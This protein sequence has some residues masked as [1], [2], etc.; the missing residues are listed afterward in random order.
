MARDPI[1]SPVDV[2]P[3]PPRPS[4]EHLKNE[5]KQR[6]KRLRAGDPH[7]KLAAAQ[8]VVARQYGFSS[9]RPLKAHVD[10]RAVEKTL[11]HGL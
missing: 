1:S 6:L 3:L 5:A 2:R 8:L 9:W 11:R 4:L 7:A 10:K